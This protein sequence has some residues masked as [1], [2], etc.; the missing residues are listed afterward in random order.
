LSTHDPN[1]KFERKMLTPAN[2]SPF[3][4]GLAMREKALERKKVKKT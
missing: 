2:L 3:N 4:S 1:V